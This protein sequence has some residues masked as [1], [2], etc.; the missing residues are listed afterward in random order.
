MN[1]IRKFLFVF[2]FLFAILAIN[3]VS[4]TN[5]YPVYT[6]PVATA[7]QVSYQPLTYDFAPTYN[8]K[9]TTLATNYYYPPA[10]VNYVPENKYVNFNAAPV[11]VYNYGNYYNGYN[12][13]NNYYYQPIYRYPVYQEPYTKTTVHYFS[14]WN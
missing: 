1:T 7:Y 13:M 12:N 8:A 4:A 6:S 9:V 3:L 2:A 11:Y 10:Y 5:Y 14:M